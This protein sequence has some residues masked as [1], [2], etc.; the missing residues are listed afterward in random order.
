VLAGVPLPVAPELLVELE[1]VLPVVEVV[2]VVPA[3]VLV[4]AVVEVVLVV[5]A[6]VLVPAVVEVVLVVPVVVCVIP[7]APLHAQSA[8]V[9]TRQQISF[10]KV[11]MC[12]RPYP[13]YYNGNEGQS[14][15]WRDAELPRTSGSE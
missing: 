13:P 11:V 1:F 7:I 8:T 10:S 14:L 15:A 9:V 3:V 12:L 5:P 2:L 6:V 4:P